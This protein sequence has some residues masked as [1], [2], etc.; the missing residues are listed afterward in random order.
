MTSKK[1]R[2]RAPKEINKKFKKKTSVLVTDKVDFVDYKD[3]NLLNRFVSD[4]SKIRNRR[5][6]GNTVQ[7]QRDIANAVKNA[8]E[9]ALLPYTKRVS[10]TRAGRPPRDRDEDGGGRGGR[11]DGG[12]RGG[13]DSFTADPVVPDL[14]PVDVDVVD[15][16]VDTDDETVEA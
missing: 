1:N 6:T 8:R 2:A 14:G 11:E 4:R 13:R 5:V 16:D 15:T 12:G 7:Q 10:Q 9:M 3:V